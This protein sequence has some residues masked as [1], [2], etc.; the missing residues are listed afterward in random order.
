MFFNKKKSNGMTVLCQIYIRR[1]L[2][3]K[4]DEVVEAQNTELDAV[5]N[6]LNAWTDLEQSLGTM[7]LV[8]A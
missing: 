7:A 5:I 4:Q 8:N 3:G 2:L 6:Y 1:S